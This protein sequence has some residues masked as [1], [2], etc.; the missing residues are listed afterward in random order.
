[1]KVRS[2]AYYK[3]VDWSPVMFALVAISIAAIGFVK[4][5]TG[6]GDALAAVLA[7]GWLLAAEFAE[8]TRNTVA[9]RRKV[10]E[11]DRRMQVCNIRWANA[12][13]DAAMER[14]ERS[15]DR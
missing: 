7:L 12:K 4:C 11:M 1:M 15:C 8:T 9:V 2:R 13:I 14:Y 3:L 5:V 6:N 10:D